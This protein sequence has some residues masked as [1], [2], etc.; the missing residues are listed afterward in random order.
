VGKQLDT[1]ERTML[2]SLC[3]LCQF[4]PQGI[5]ENIH[6]VKT[7]GLPMEIYNSETAVK[8]NTNNPNYC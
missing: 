1:T 2:K 8:I 6:M 7:V 4:C 5:T 3:K